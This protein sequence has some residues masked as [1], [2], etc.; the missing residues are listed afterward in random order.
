MFMKAV[1]KVLLIVLLFPFSVAL[2]AQS[3]Q[4]PIKDFVLY[5]TKDLKL[6]EKIKV[7]P[8]GTT[9]GNLGSFKNISFKKESVINGNIYSRE[10][11]D[12]DK[13]ITLTGNLFANNFSNAKND[14]LKGEKSIK[15]T[16]NAVINGNIKLS[17]SGSSFIGSVRQKAGATYSGPTPTLGRTTGALTLPIFPTLPL[18]NSYTAGTTRVSGTQTIV[19]GTYGDVTLTNGQ[20]LTLNGVGTYVFKSI[21]NTSDKR[22]NIIYNFNNIARGQFRILVEGNVDLKFVNASIINGGE[23]GRIY[24][25]IHSTLKPPNRNDDDKEDGDYDDDDNAFFISSGSGSTGAVWLG[26]VWVPNGKVKIKSTSNATVKF[27]GAIWCGDKIYIEKNAEIK[28]A[29]LIFDPNTISP[30]Y[31]APAT[32][33]TTDLIGSALTQLAT[34]TGVI[35]SIP[36]NNIFTIVNDKVTISICCAISVSAKPRHDQYC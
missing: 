3:Q 23:A 28:Y 10:S 24:T 9:R 35:T 6:S 30:Y 34:N 2:K 32:G 7:L 1:L 29:P 5:S 13:E 20:T 25:E 26:T 16:G 11:I 27:E 8:N 31:P 19:P 14:I 4:L 21:K 15:I 12:L 22:V 17:G 36:N 33:K 18:I